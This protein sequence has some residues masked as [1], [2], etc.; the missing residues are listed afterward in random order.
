MYIFRIMNSNVKA[1]GKFHYN[2]LLLDTQRYKNYSFSIKKLLRLVKII[3]G[4]YWL[5]GGIS[6]K[7]KELSKVL[8]QALC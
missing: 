7:G 6:F 3:F 5:L 4:D 8:L 1:R 2:S